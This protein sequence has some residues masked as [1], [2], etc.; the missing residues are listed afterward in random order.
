METLDEVVFFTLLSLDVLAG[1]RL[2]FKKQLA[3]P[4]LSHHSLQ[5]RMVE[6]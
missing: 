4:A 5:R 6:T 3:S 2:S 1:S